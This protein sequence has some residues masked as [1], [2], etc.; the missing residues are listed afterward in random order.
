MRMGY[1]MNVQMS[2]VVFLVVQL[3]ILDVMMLELLSVVV[4]HKR[5]C[6]TQS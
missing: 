4:V 3:F 5:G 2:V 1:Q 6:L